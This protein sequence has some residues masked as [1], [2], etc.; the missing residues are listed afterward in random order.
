[1]EEHIGARI[2]YWRKR[3]GGMTQ[4]VLAGL[5][6]VSQPF[7][8]QVESG[9]KGI[10][11][12]STMVAIAGALQVSVADLL[13]GP[14][15]PT[16]PRRVAADAAI[17]AIRA[18]LAEI[19]ED[20]R[21]PPTMEPD[22]FTVAVDQLDGLRVRADYASMAP[23]LP[24]A[25]LNAAYDGHRLAR[26]AYH[27]GDVLKNLGY[28]D[29]A[30]TAA[31][32]GVRAALDDGDPGWIGAA[33][34]FYTA[35]LPLE[36]AGL[37][38]RVAAR[39]LT[40][41]Q[42]HAADPRARQML[43]QLHLSASLACAVDE[44]P[45]A[46]AAHLHEADREARS[47][48]DPGDGVGFNLSAFGPTNLGLWRMT[49]AG[50]LGEHGRVIELAR[51]LNPGRLKVADRHYSYW[52]TYGA[53][54]AHSSRHDAEALAAFMHAERSAPVPFSV[55]QLART[56]VSGM[57]RRASRRGVPNDLRI[58]AKRLGIQVSP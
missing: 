35:A 7:I 16:D 17:P 11:R 3:R 37:K 58:I 32:I 4:A 5:A 8:S 22:E 28:Q 15:D 57:V 10:E 55:S 20:E 56:A 19:E 51:A 39:S 43:G 41:L 31:R 23:L 2:A 18:V 29:L 33:R 21:R 12:R 27:A 47:L 50:E 9:R 52:L 53:A 13:G 36:A 1:V 34:Y 14:A 48:G 24:A 25:L 38:S 42:A 49:V 6:G 45:D 54:L 46:A 30:L 40:D 26:V 44:R